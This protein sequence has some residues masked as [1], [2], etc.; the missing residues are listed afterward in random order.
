MPD[1]IAIGQKTL[2]LVKGDITDLEIEAFVYYARHDLQLGSGF[3]NAIAQRGG[4]SVQEELDKLGRAETTEAVVTGAGNM[5]TRFI[6]HAV[7]PRFQEENLEDK[8][9]DTVLSCL[10]RAEEKE[11]KSIAFPAMGA[12]FYGVPL[13]MSAEVTLQTAYDYLAKGTQIQEV[14]VSLLDNREYEHFQKK[15][16]ALQRTA[17]AA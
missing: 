9:H 8:L 1:S 11:I 12:G 2:R 17:A 4:P 6:I 15:L 7:G 5:K 3:G 16:A 14:V 10:A 13:P